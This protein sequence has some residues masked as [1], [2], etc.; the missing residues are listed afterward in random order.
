MKKAFLLAFLLAAVV[1]LAGCAANQETQFPETSTAI[2]RDPMSAVNPAGDAE[3]E[4]DEDQ[5]DFDWDSY[6][7]ASEEDNGASFMAGAVYDDMGNNVYA[8]ASPIPLNPIDMP[9]A[10]PRPALTFAYGPVEIPSLRLSFEAPAGWTVDASAADTVVITDPNTYD[11]YNASMTISITPVSNSYKLNDV[12]NTVRDKLKEI[13]QYNY[14]KWTTTTLSPRTL[15]KKD[16]YY[17]NYRGEYY[18]GTVVRGRVMVALLDGNKIITLHMSC[19]GWY[20]ESYMNVVA[21]FRD[22]VKQQ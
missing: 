16:G 22:T 6:D 10:T 21:K 1:L 8:G 17:A 19:P 20:N 12:K 13:G 18:D 14:S 7:P 9:T 5:S 11:N 2:Q 15:L 3:D 4:G